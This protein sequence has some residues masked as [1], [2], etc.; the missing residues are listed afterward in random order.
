[1]KTLRMGTPVTIGDLE[2]IPVEATHIDASRAAGALVG[3]ASK[4]AA[5]IVVRSR[6]GAWALSPE[7]D[8]ASLEELVREVPGLRERV[9]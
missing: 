9:E 3:F 2:L 8:E 6:A 7:G 4:S 1:M 5:A